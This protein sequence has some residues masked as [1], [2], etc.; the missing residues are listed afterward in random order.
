M[1]TQKEQHFGKIAEKMLNGVKEIGISCLNIKGQRP[2]KNGWLTYINTF[3]ILD[4][5]ELTNLL[6]RTKLFLNEPESI[7]FILSPEKNAFK[8]ELHKFC[9][10]K[11][12]A[13]FIAKMFDTEPYKV[14]Y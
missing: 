9:N 6:I 2:V 7:Y 3:D 11:K 12:Q 4:E 10:D 5:L 14:L 1:K 8:V 13:K